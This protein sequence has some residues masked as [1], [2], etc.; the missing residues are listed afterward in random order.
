MCHVNELKP[1]QPLANSASPFIS[2]PLPESAQIGWLVRRFETT[3]RAAPVSCSPRW[4]K[5]GSCARGS[6][7]FLL[8]RRVKIKGVISVTSSA[9]FQLARFR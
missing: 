5:L 9:S 1:P 3:A 4:K 7:F 2:L 8:V 6:L